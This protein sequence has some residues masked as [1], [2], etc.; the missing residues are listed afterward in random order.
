M[1]K[2]YL[3]ELDDLIASL[4]PLPDDDMPEPLTDME[5]FVMDVRAG[6]SLID[7]EAVFINNLLMFSTEDSNEKRVCL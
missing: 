5:I 4:P 3:K 1:M 7:T 2:A 6:L